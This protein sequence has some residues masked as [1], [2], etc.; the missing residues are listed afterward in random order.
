MDAVNWAEDKFKEACEGVKKYTK[1]IGY[2]EEK[3]QFVP[4]AAF[5]GVNTSK[6]A[7]EMPWYKGPTLIAALDNFALPNKPT[8]KPLRLPIQDVYSITGIGTVPVG[9]V[10]TGLIKPGM[11]VHFNPS[12]KT[13][14]VKSVEM[15]HE[16]LPQ[17]GPG[18]NVGFNCRGLAKDDIRRGD[19]AAPTDK[20][21]TVAKT[22]TAQIIVL[23]HPSVISVG[24]TPVFHAYTAQTACTITEIKKVVR[25][26]KEQE[27]KSHMKNGDSGVVK[28]TP[29]RPLVVERA[30]EFP[31]LGRF[32]I[33]DMGQT[34]AVGVA[35]EVEPR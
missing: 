3:V 5:S 35:I 32:A 22:F 27:D 9:K 2:K 33:R 8:D 6:P 17:A 23:N 16:M 7:P 20:P 13:A 30:T 19:V 18:D 28:I 11:M 4:V 15:H 25:A 12:N 10:E 31:P 24:Y 21:A 34:V 26:G 29:T 14:E 1:L